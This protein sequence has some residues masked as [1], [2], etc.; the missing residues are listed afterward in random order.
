MDK[1]R[2][3]QPGSQVDSESNASSLEIFRRR[4]ERFS[5]EA[6]NQNE[7]ISNTTQTS[8]S[9]TTLIGNWYEDVFD[10]KD[11]AKPK[12]VPSQYNHYFETTYRNDISKKRPPVPKV[13]SQY[14]E[15]EAAAYPA[16]QPILDTSRA[17]SEYNSYISTY[18]AAYSPTHAADKHQQQQQDDEKVSEAPV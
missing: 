14:R 4:R 12:C 9:T 6:I 5:E 15:P 16:H 13:L 1:T 7:W 3:N 10:I 2:G 18:S 8:Y 11:L 17:K